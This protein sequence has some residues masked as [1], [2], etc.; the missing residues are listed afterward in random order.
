MQGMLQLGV[1]TKPHGLKGEVKAFV[2]G[3]DP[4][5]FEDYDNVIVQTGKK[6]IELSIENV[7][8]FKNLTILKF[9][10]LDKIE[11]IQ[12]FSGSKI[13]IPREDALPL[14]EYEYYV[15][16]IIGSDVFLDDGT[17]FGKLKDVL[18]TGAN[19]V[20]SVELEDRKEVL[21]PSIKD[22]ILSVEPDN[23]KMVIH[24]LDGLM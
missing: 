11:D 22:C 10:G 15:D 1:I 8:Y 12:S 17:F 7:R 16:D 3:D 9:K 24:L 19:D 21:I 5:V 14:G 18:R 23:K 13:L 4:Y 6:K 20:Y 2:T